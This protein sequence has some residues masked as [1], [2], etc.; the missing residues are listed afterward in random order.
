MNEFPTDEELR[1]AYLP[2][3]HAH[4][5]RREELLDRVSRVAPKN[6]QVTRERRRFAGMV[7][8]LATM[9]LVAV[10]LAIS[11]WQTGA[12]SAVAMEQ[13]RERLLGIRSLYLKGWTYQ[14]VEKDGELKVERFPLEFY[15]ERPS[16]YWFNSHGFS[17]ER[18]H[19][20]ANV[21]HHF[22]ACDGTQSIFVS[23]N[24]RLAVIQPASRLQTQLET[25][26]FLQARIFDRLLAGLPRA[27]RHVT[28]EEVQG[29]SCQVFEC[30]EDT[31]VGFR[32]RRRVWLDTRTRMP[33]RVKAWTSSPPR[34]EEPDFEYH[35]I[36][37]DG[38][39]REGMFSFKAP[40]G[41]QVS[42]TEG[43]ARPISLPEDPSSSGGD[44]SFYTWIPFNID[45][46]AVLYCWKASSRL[47]PLKFMQFMPDF[48][49]GPPG[50]ERP[51]RYLTLRSDPKWNWS[52]LLPEREE[53][54][55]G[56]D[57]Q[58]VVV[59]K[60]ARSR[61]QGGG[62]PV[63]LSTELLDRVLLEAQKLTIPAGSDAEP[64]TVR[65]IRKVLD[66]DTP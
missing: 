30:Q 3:S 15:A 42:V 12:S 59:L 7:L 33:V 39:P 11:F 5:R 25:E 58:L 18:E 10:T 40:E 23:H 48:F 50:E 36:R 4:D 29:V 64:F 24:D 41:Y 52:L 49:L 56:L 19:K 55:I 17:Y 62:R 53:D 2:F 21:T 9:L 61:L 26:V 43:Q 45:D 46:R 22:A 6:T 20:L 57:D 32:H 1:Q 54:R 28:V 51:C 66:P 60:G 16:R 47:E 27:Y 37:I 8:S 31:K 65:E 44:L 38:P 63:R 14:T 34:A 35:T 13:A